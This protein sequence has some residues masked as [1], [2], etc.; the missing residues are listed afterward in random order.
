MPNPQRSA[1]QASRSQTVASQRVT[2]DGLSFTG[3]PKRPVPRTRPL[4]K[5]VELTAHQQAVIHPQPKFV[6]SAA[7]AGA[8][9][10][11]HPSLPLPTRQVLERVRRSVWH[12]VIRPSFREAPDRRALW[13]SL[14][15]TFLSIFLWLL[16][17]T[18]ALV[19][20]GDTV[21]NQPL[22]RV[23]G[24]VYGW[25]HLVSPLNLLI[26]VAGFTMLAT[27]IWILRHTLLLVSYG[28]HIRRIDHR[29]VS[30]R[31]LF[32]Q[33]IA[34]TGRFAV[35]ALF[36]I[37]LTASIAVVG[38]VLIRLV[39]TDPAA[40]FIPY[41][42]YVIGL[43]LLGMLVGF[44]LLA[45]HRPL[46]RV[47]LAITD[48]PAS[49]IVI[50]SFGLV[51]SSRK[52]AFLIGLF[53]LLLAGLAVTLLFGI[54]WATSVYGLLQVKS[55]GGRVGLIVLSAFLTYSVAAGFTIWTQ[56]Y[57]PHAYHALAHSGQIN[58]S[59][60]MTGEQIRKSRRQAFAH[61]GLIIVGLAIVLTGLVFA[62]RQ[63]V[64]NFLETSRDRLP[65]SLE[66]ALPAIPTPN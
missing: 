23:Y 53:W 4:P 12:G 30:A 29:L 42:S 28:I 55:T 58:V 8:N 24:W 6:P 49:Y 36:D 34:R 64:S 45:T 9:A 61:L 51:A 19:V 3:R 20:A 11:S 50:K 59:D 18:P 47:M 38:I 46:T 48:R 15:A 10:V 35:V 26:A 7:G 22:D 31:Q 37:L 16:I 44:W 41:Q 54:L 60:L 56:G 33:G 62:V 65:A 63:P 43:I 1:P 13:A 66:D 52:R 27:L 39:L 57:W 2:V 25:L 5:A 21:V 17:L 32:W 40:W 14:G